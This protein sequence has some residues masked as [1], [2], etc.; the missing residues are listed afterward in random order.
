MVA[1]QMVF[2]HVSAVITRVDQDNPEA[3]G[4]FTWSE[5]ELVA[6]GRGTAGC[7]RS[8]LILDR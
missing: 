8:F 6:R 2:S 1:L 7:Q 5:R 4:N 3:H